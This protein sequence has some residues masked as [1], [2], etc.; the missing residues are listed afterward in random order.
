[1][2]VDNTD[3]SEIVSELSFDE[4]RELPVRM[5]M[6]LDLSACDDD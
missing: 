4:L 3:V 5:Q 1:M 6:G 2:M